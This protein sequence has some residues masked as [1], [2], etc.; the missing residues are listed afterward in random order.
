M[1]IPR[2]QL[3]AIAAQQRVSIAPRP[4]DLAKIRAMSTA[5]LKAAMGMSPAET[6]HFQEWL[7]V[8]DPAQGAAMGMSP[9]EMVHFQEWLSGTGPQQGA[10]MADEVAKTAEHL[11]DIGHLL[12]M[13]TNDEEFLKALQLPGTVTQRACLSA[14]IVRLGLMRI[15]D[16]VEKDKAH[17]PLAKEPK[18]K[19]RVAGDRWA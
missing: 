3:R 12:Y 19:V 14:Q 9:A 1:S 15:R 6:A 11:R 10:A 2:E 17:E 16:Q 18:D 7:P 4:E 13:I 8:T 5:E